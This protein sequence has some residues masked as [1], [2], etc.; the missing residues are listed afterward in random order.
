M[1]QNGWQNGTQLDPKRIKIE[2]QL[3]D[4]ERHAL[5][6]SSAILEPSWAD[7]GTPRGPK[8]LVLSFGFLIIFEHQCF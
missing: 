7:R 8:K 3:E 4:E 2:D 5:G 6:Q 1:E